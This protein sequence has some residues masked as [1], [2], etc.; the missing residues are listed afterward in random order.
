[1]S[2][3][4]QRRLRSGISGL[5]EITMGGF[6]PGCSYLVRGGPG[7]GKTTLCAHFAL[8]GQEAQEPV[9]WIALSEAPHQVKANALAQGL[10]LDHVTFLDLTPGPE[11]FRDKKGYEV[12]PPEEVETGPLAERIVHA[13]ETVRPTRVIVDS[14]SQLQFLISN[15][16]QFY[17]QV[18]SLLRFLSSGGATVLLTSEASPR[19]P[20][21]EVQFLVDGVIELNVDGMDWRLQVK[22]WRGSAFRAGFHSFALTGCG[23][24]VFPRLE[25]Q[26]VARDTALD[27]LSSGIPAL[28]ELLMG[29]INRGTVTLI[30]GPS[31]TGKTTLGLQF[32]KEAA[33]RGERSVV[34]HFE[35][36]QRTLIN[37]GERVNIPI[38][39]MIAQKTLR[40]ERIE[41]LALSADQFAQLVREEVEERGTTMVMLDSVA[42]Y[43]LSVRGGDVA[44]SLHALTQYLTNSGVTTLICA[45]VEKIT[46]DFQITEVGISYLADNVI[47]LR[48]F[49]SQGQ[50]RKAI[51]VLKKRLSDFEKSVRELEITPYGLKVGAPLKD[52]RGLL[53]GTPEL[54]PNTPPP[55]S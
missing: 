12:F 11:V 37:R 50:L 39:R 46:G 31:G 16:H 14:V 2:D 28:D 40:L 33:S 15:V 1:M 22:K 32:M 53:T 9:L 21:E 42:G 35:E 17:Q 10:D 18:L 27:V 26:L 25:P 48:Y 45:E 36:N 51:G 13:M 29:G 6:L 47:F 43:R 38:A 49:E 20:D 4:N 55:N 41:P 30:A 19:A 7:S 24:R 54:A 8:A 34:F 5:D 44:S 23:V 52:F 3:K